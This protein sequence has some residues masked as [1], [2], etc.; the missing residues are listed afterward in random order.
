M[1]QVKIDEKSNEITAILRPLAMME[2]EGAI[3]TINAMGCQRAVARTIG[4]EKADYV[5]ALK[6]NQ[7]ALHD[8]VTLFVAEKKT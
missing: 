7:G 1:G 3:V 5:L 2:I 6:G 4:D 8:D